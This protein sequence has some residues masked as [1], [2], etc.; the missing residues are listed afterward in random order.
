MRGIWGCRRSRPRSGRILTEFSNNA[1]LR[2]HA[3]RWQHIQ[4][5]K[6]FSR[7]GEHGQPERFEVSSLLPGTGGT[8]PTVFSATEKR[9]SVAEKLIS[10]AQTIV[11]ASDRLVSVVEVI[12]STTEMSV[13]MMEII[14]SVS[15]KIVSGSGIV[16]SGFLMIVSGLEITV[17]GTKMIAKI[18]YSANYLKIHTLHVV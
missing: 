3:S 15:E 8:V 2:N 13:L 17:S 4:I 7:I 6:V 18:G 9:V 1:H 10:G 5:R 16:V 11:S 14:G 12:V